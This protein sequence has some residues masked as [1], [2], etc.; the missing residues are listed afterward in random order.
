LLAGTTSAATAKN[1]SSVSALYRRSDA[2][3]SR[4]IAIAALSMIVAVFSG[5]AGVIGVNLGSMVC[6]LIGAI[7]LLGMVGAVSRPAAA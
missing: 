7:I 3:R 5:H 6:A 4:Q 2:P 1:V